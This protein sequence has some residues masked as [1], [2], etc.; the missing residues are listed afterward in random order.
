MHT[1]RP[2]PGE[3]KP[4]LRLAFFL[5]RLA[6]PCKNSTLLYS[7]QEEK[8]MGIQDRD[9]Y[10]EAVRDRERQLKQKTRNPLFTSTNP[11]PSWASATL[12]TIVYC[13]ATYGALSI[14]KRLFG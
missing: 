5:A 11:S 12:K 8:P 2:P 1:H 4:A 9:W 6:W 14:F 10:R 13:L 3:K 7:F